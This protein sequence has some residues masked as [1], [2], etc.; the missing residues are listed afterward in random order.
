MPFQGFL[1]D[2]VVLVVFLPLSFGFEGCGQGSPGFHQRSPVVSVEDAPTP[3][4]MRVKIVRS[5]FDI[6]IPPPPM[7]VALK[8]QLLYREGFARFAFGR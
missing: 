7:G 8:S 5:L 2:F 1:G 4:L 6:F 3:T